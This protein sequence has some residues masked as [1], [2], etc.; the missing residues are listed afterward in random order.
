MKSYRQ[1][2]NKNATF[3]SFPQ[4]VKITL[5][6]TPHTIIVNNKEDQIILPETSIIKPTFKE[7]VLDT[8]LL[9]QFVDVDKLL[10]VKQS[11]KINVYEL[12]QLKDLA[13]KLHISF[14]NINKG[15]L[16][17]KIKNLYNYYFKDQNN[18]I[19]DLK[20]VSKI[21]LTILNQLF[22]E[23]RIPYEKKTE[24][25]DKIKPILKTQNEPLLS[26]IKVLE[27]EWIVPKK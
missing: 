21:N 27:S 10:D 16:I 17:E 18:L 7:P 5:P 8:V 3:Q 25:L 24:L 15:N 9:L 13:K 19:G 11:K 12:Y 23:H 20:Q 1:P 6:E 14:S 26:I 2:I 4:Q 22:D